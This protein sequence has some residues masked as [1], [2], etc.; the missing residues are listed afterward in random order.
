MDPGTTTDTEAPS[1]RTLDRRSLLVAGGVAVV[2][3][4]CAAPSSTSEP[5]S[6]STTPAPGPTTTTTRPPASTTTTAAPAAPTTPGT[7]GTPAVD[8]LA[9]GDA[10]F[11]H[12]A[13]RLAF[14][15]TPEVLVELRRLGTTGWIDSQLAWSTIDDSAADAMVAAG[16]PRALWTPERIADDVTPWR[17]PFDLATATVVRATWGRRPLYELLVDFWGNHL[18]IDANRWPL[19][20]HMP[21]FHRDVIRAHATGTFSD[22]LVAS[23]QHPAMLIYLDQASSRADGDQPPIENYARE[24]LEL[25]TVGLGGGYDETDVKEVAYLLSGWT[26]AD[27]RSGGF[28]FRSDW[29]DM[30]P[31]AAGGDVLGWAPGGLTGRAAGESFLRHLARHPNTANRLAHKAAV[32]FIGEHVTPTDA[33]VTSAAKAYTDNDTAIVPMIRTLLT[34]SAFRSSAN[35]KARRPF[36][37]LVACLRGARARWE[38][39]MAADFLW[40]CN[41]RL[42]LLGQRPHRWPAPNGYPDANRAWLNAGAMV[43]RWNLASEIARGAWWG[44]SFVDPPGV[45]G[46]PAPATVGQAV[47]RLAD[48]VLGEPLDAASRRAILTTTGLTQDAPWESWYPANSLLAYVLQSPQAQ[49][50]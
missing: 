31:L 3:A 29:H 12:H 49:M 50:R 18:N 41:A 10:Q 44:A 45:L 1:R 39:D 35:L 23:A 27:A 36:E 46:N 21:A 2:A 37:Y 9:D 19:I 38:P 47:D 40:Y 32:R 25:H 20:T 14:S 26:V 48:A 43:N 5:A 4:A 22:M 15:P 7:P 34:S 6:P 17:A 13:R 11:L 16:Y 42:D 33:V 30:G 28:A 24:L 8:P